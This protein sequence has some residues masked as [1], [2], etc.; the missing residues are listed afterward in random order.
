MLRLIFT[1]FRFYF[2]DTDMRLL[3]ISAEKCA[4]HLR[5][6]SVHWNYPVSKSIIWWKLVNADFFTRKEVDFRDCICMQ[7][8]I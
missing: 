1:E 7:T 5:K 8:V 4:S 2:A 6:I 3:Q